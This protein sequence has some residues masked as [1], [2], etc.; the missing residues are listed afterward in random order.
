MTIAS[1]GNNP[2]PF[3][4]TTGAP[5]PLGAIDAPPEGTAL[6]VLN[7]SIPIMVLALPF[8]SV[9]DLSTFAE[10]QIDIGLH[11]EGAT[12]FFIWRFDAGL[13]KMCFDTPFHVG[14][15]HSSPFDDLA[16]RSATTDEL[17]TISVVLQ[18]E[19]GIVRA[20][21]LVSLP[22]ALEEPVRKAVSE[23]LRER[24]LTNL[25]RQHQASIKRFYAR[26]PS[27]ELALMLA[28]AKGQASAG[29]GTR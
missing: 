13:S 14:L 27:V 24:R 28:Q 8:P 6:M 7:A 3:I 15:E 29:I 5:S 19:R 16:S 9:H 2:N 11:R 23:Q 26:M 17:R 1:D 18:D 22:R 25:S 4:F 21:R 10:G 12:A 20:I